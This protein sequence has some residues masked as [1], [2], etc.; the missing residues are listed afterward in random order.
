[1]SFKY[2]LALLLALTLAAKAEPIAIS[3]TPIASFGLGNAT[4]FGPLGWRGGLQLSSP[5]KTFGGLSGL[6]LSEDCESLLAVSDTGRWFRATLSYE[7][8]KLVGLSQGEW[9]PILDAKGQ[10]PVN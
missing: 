1:M 3:T 5:D 8:G 2:A 6:T 10:P 4:E 9:A 7:N